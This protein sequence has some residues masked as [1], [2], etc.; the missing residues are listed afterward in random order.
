MKE[1]ATV[2][3]RL[4]L[5]GFGGPLA[6]MAMMEEETSRKRGW[7]TPKR[8]TELYAVCKVLPGPVST[9][10]AIYIGLIRGGTLGGLLSGVFFILP[11]FLIVL[12]LSYLYVYSGVVQKFSPAFSAIQA[13]AIAV[14]LLSVIQLG[15]PYKSQLLS[16]IIG[17]LSA[18]AIVIRPGWEPGIILFWGILGAA[19]YSRYTPKKAAVLGIGVGGLWS[20]LSASPA[21]AAG[22]LNALKSSVLTKLFW[23]CF[24]AGAFVFG[25][26]LAIVP[27]L[28]S[29]VVQRFHWMTHAEFLDGLAIGQMT[30]GPV[31]ISS[32]FIGYKTAGLC[33]AIV[34]AAGM[35]L[36]G[37]VNILLIVP[38]VWKHISGTPIA[39]GFIAWAFPAVIGGIFG[40]LIRL[41]VVTLNAPVPVAAFLGTMG[42]AIRFKTPAWVLIP[43]SG[44]TT[45][46]G[47]LILNR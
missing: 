28:E 3:L 7:I 42:L 17:L 18:T 13:S 16:W 14:I 34:A 20:L 8:F 23:V 37:F 36:P 45:V 2:F 30:P 32:T 1:I 4:G 38:R 39:S 10:M 44:I 29:D 15:R 6:A 12:G 22:C 11:S 35:F 47:Q 24:K 31:V 41:G 43:L 5:L 33:G 25:T 19:L 26:G 9:Q 46:V 27:I 40:V 21:A